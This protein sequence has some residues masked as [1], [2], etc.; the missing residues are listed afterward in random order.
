MNSVVNQTYQNIELIVID[1]G[2]TDNSRIQ[3]KSPKEDYIKYT[4]QKN[5]GVSAARN[6]GLSLA[7]GSYILFLDADD[8]L[9]SDFITN[10]L[11][12]LESNKEYDACTSSIEIINEEGKNQDKH[13]KN[14]SRIEDLTSFNLK[15]H[16]CPSGYLFRVSALIKYQLTFNT[17]LSSS[18]DKLFLYDFLKYAKIGYTGN[19]PLFYRV[20]KSSMSNCLTENLVNDHI[21]YLNLIKQKK[22]I[23]EKQRKQVQS[24]INY[25][26]GASFFHLKKRKK[27]LSFLFKSILLSPKTFLNLINHTH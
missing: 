6:H 17:N 7:K 2:S 24:R 14:A 4:F 21:V 13:F 25:T 10:R 19:S 3:I 9:S 5:K 23:P 18:A 20:F 26:I 12:F 11:N 22:V 8:I 1:D 27:A 16:T 15:T